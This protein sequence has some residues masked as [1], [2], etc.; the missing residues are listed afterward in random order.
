M[1]STRSA[2]FKISD[3]DQAVKLCVSARGG[4]H[5]KDGNWSLIKAFKGDTT[6]TTGSVEK[7]SL[8]L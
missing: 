5:I 1:A 8:K 2:V 6:K 4:N 3:F 7:R